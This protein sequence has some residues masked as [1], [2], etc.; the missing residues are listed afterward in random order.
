MRQREAAR[1]QEPEAKAARDRAITALREK[2]QEEER[3]RREEA[4]VQQKL[5]KMGVCC[6]GFRWIKQTEGYRCAR[7]SHYNAQL[8]I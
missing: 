3:R 6:A 8:S 2:Q 4:R 7:G 1:I 5:R